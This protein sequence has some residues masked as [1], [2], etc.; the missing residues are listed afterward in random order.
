MMASSHQQSMLTASWAN[1]KSF[2][3]FPAEPTITLILKNNIKI[4]DEF[5][6]MSI[7]YSPQN[8]KLVFMHKFLAKLSSNLITI[9]HDILHLY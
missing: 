5:N 4:F 3:I 6:N 7:N 2:P 1:E 9:G 8:I